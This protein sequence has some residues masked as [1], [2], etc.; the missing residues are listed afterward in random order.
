MLIQVASL[1]LDE[2][3]MPIRPGFQFRS[4]FVIVQLSAQVITNF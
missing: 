2:G 4:Y 3:M 1:L